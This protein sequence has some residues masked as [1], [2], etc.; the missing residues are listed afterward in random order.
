MLQGMPP[1]AIPNAANF[2]ESQL[3]DLAGN[4]FC[5]DLAGEEIVEA[6]KTLLGEAG[7]G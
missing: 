6:R 1:G 3:M 7:V 2:N 4:A 5:G